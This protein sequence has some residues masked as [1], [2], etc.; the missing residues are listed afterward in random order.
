MI[1]GEDPIKEPK[2]AKTKFLPTQLN[3]SKNW[4][5]TSVYHTKI[6]ISINADQCS[7][8]KGH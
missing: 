6:I 2:K 7:M 1:S 4:V 3:T 8:I 5:N